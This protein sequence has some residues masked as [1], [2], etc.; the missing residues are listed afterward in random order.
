MEPLNRNYLIFAALLEGLYWRNIPLKKTGIVLVIMSIIF[1]SVVYCMEYL[2]FQTK[3]Y[4]NRT[5]LENV[6]RDQVQLNS[7]LIKITFLGW[8]GHCLILNGVFS[9]LYFLWL[10]LSDQIFVEVVPKLT[11]PVQNMTLISFEHTRQSVFHRASFLGL[12]TG[13]GIV[14]SVLTSLKGL[15]VY[16]AFLSTFHFLE[17]VC[18]A[19]NSTQVTLS[20]FLLN[21]SPEYTFATFASLLE[22][23]IE[24][25][26]FP[27]LKSWNWM[28]NLAI[29]LCLLG[30]FIR[31]LAMLTAKSNFTHL[32]RITKVSGHELVK[33]GIY[34]Y[35]RHPSYTGFFYWAIALQ[36]IL[37]NPLC[38]VAYIKILSKFFSDRIVTEETALIDFFGKEYRDY[39]KTTY[40]LIPEI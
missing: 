29:V 4:L 6:I 21:H 37:M 31:S 1:R 23:A 8:I 16:I 34:K 19:V 22:Y 3:K 28:T 30:Q 7:L 18:I 10:L 35:F 5:D 39:R 38:L 17:Y 13:L 27:S 14:M 12:F 9:G 33:T 36:I 40:L 24:W 2:S 32:V 26:L 25:Y 20:A 15:G 11:I